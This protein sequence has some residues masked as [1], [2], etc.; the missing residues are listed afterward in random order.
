[1]INDV[2][3]IGRQSFLC[4]LL[5]KSSCL[6]LDFC[7]ARRY[8]PSL[9][10]SKEKSSAFGLEPSSGFCLGWI[11]WHIRRLLKSVFG[12]VTSMICSGHPYRVVGRSI[13]KWSKDT[14]SDQAS[15]HGDGY[16]TALLLTIFKACHFMKCGIGVDF[17]VLSAPS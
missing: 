2:K 5:P 15:I 13:A 16:W 9:K 12:L 8:P 11:E 7:P 4:S 6:S 3:K 17:R 10:M 1:M 14:P